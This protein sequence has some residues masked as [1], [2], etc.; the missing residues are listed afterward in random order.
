MSETS[1]KK[2]VTDVTYE[3]VNGINTDVKANFNVKIRVEELKK[4]RYISYFKREISALKNSHVLGHHDTFLQAA[5][6]CNS[7]LQFKMVN[8][9][10]NETLPEELLFINYKIAFDVSCRMI[11]SPIV[12]QF[13]DNDWV[14]K[15]EI[16][17]NKLDIPNG[18]IPDN[19]LKDRIIY[20]IAY[21]DLH[22]LDFNKLLFSDFLH[23][24]YLYN[25]K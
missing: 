6:M 5:C 18:I 17:L 1:L 3:I 21:Y 4:G 25:L 8:F 2:M 20:M 9:D 24:L 23:L 16:E 10:L 19:P 7:L 11:F 14:P 12:Y 22:G 15:P 13:K